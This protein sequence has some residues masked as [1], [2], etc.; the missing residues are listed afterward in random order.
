MQKVCVLLFLFWCS[1]VKSKRS[2]H[3]DG[4]WESNPA[5]IMLNARGEAEEDITICIS[6]A[7][8][9]ACRVR[10]STPHSHTSKYWFCSLVRLKFSISVL[11]FIICKGYNCDSKI[12]LKPMV[13]TC[14]SAVTLVQNT[15]KSA[16]GFR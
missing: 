14:T 13:G 8:Q 7:R 9:K 3:W 5:V 11:N 16:C 4:N 12:S 2:L 15:R 1:F 6:G 10:D